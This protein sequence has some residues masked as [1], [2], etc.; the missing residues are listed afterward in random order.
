[1]LDVETELR[2]SKLGFHDLSAEFSQ[3][4]LGQSAQIRSDHAFVARNNGRSGVKMN[5]TLKINLFIFK[6][7]LILPA[8]G[9]RPSS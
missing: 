5:G 2:Q 4:R 7:L 3:I 1:M 6:E 9:E 8:N